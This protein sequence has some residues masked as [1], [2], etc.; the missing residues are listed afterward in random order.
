MT[1][2]RLHLRE[3]DPWETARAALRRWAADVEASLVPRTFAIELST[4]DLP[5]TLAITGARATGVTLVRATDFEGSGRVISGGS[6]EWEPVEG[7]VRL[8]DVSALAGSTRYL[9]LFEVK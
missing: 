9:C 7:G 4:S 5:R 6:V 2:E 3:R 8:H 1:I